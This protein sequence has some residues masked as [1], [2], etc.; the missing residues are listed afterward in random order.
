MTIIQKIKQ[1]ALMH[2]IGKSGRATFLEHEEAAKFERV[3]LLYQ[4]LWKAGQHKI[5]I[6]NQIDDLNFAIARELSNSDVDVQTN[7][8][9]LKAKFCGFRTSAISSEISKP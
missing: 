7:L 6:T 1:K 2:L 5:E 3:Q 9:I 8:P 4:Q